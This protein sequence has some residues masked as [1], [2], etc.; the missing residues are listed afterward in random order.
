MHEYEMIKDM[1][2]DYGTM[3]DKCNANGHCTAEYTAKRLID[4]NWRKVPEDSVVIS[5]EKLLEIASDY[6]EMAMFNLEKQKEIDQARK[7]VVKEVLD[8]L[9][10]RMEGDE[11]IFQSCA[12][13]I[14][15][16]DYILAREDCQNDWKQWLSE[17]AKEFGV[18]SDDD[19]VLTKEEYEALLLEQKRLKEMVDRIPCGYVQKEEVDYW[20]NRC[21]EI[22]EAASKETATKI[23][24][25]LKDC[26]DG[27]ALAEDVEIMLYDWLHKMANKLGIES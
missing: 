26:Y 5:K 3:C 16:E 20:K 7:Q 9:N 4:K 22:S 6:E 23:L 15:C 11:H 21:D 12:S 27:C 8:Y 2:P 18:E 14:V 10:A 19:V 25:D 13:K 17:L 24:Q 1:C